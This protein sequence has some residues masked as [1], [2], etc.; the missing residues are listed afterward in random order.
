MNNLC[1]FSARGTI[2]SIPQLLLKRKPESLLYM[3]SDPKFNISVDKI[4]DA[5]Y[6]DVDP[7]NIEVI[8]DCYNNMHISDG[9]MDI[10]QYM[11]LKYIGLSNSQLYSNN[12]VNDNIIDVNVNQNNIINTN[13]CQ[14]RE[15]P[16]VEYNTVKQSKNSNTYISIDSHKYC[17]V[18]T[19]D[20]KTI[21]LELSFY[22]DSQNSL[23]KSILFGEKEEYLIEPIC[24]GTENID[25]W[26]GM[27][28]IYANKI[29]S[30]LRDGIIYYHPYLISQ[31]L[32]ISRYESEYKAHLERYNL[33]EYSNYVSNGFNEK[34]AIT[35]PINIHTITVGDWKQG[36]TCL[37]I[38][39]FS[40]GENDI[41]GQMLFN[42][43]V[44]KK[45]NNLINKSSCG[46]KI[47]KYLSEFGLITD[48]NHVDA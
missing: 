35:Q 2:F 17:T 5:I 19:I 25:V 3:L 38:G 24:G 8:V 20:N 44:G 9:D 1:K 47:I 37:N 39:N 21:L 36:I 23:I 14:S 40:W 13:M 27:T 10:F 15:L 28:E 43:D 42:S 16:N 22:H 33:A 46:N 7:S 48:M 45:I 41:A 31:Q 18:H 12:A 11:D 30:I 4:D 6:V 29:I 26:I 32:N 34:C